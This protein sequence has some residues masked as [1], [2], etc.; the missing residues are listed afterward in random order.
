VNPKAVP[1]M[2]ILA[3]V[4]GARPGGAPRALEYAKNARA[5]APNDPEVAHAAGRAAFQVG[6]HEWAY[7]ILQD[8][9]RKQPGN[10]E[11]GYDF[12]W[13]A[14]SVGRVA[15]AETA[16][17]NVVRQG[18]NSARV[19]AAKLFVEMTALARNPAG[20]AQASPRIQTVLKADPAYVPALT[21]AA[22][23]WE[24]QKGYAEA[25]KLYEQVLGRYPEFLPAIRNLA[26]IY[27]NHLGDVQKGYD[28]AVKARQSLP[29][30]MA[31]AR[32]LGKLVSL[33][34]DHQYAVRLLNEVQQKKA[35]DAETYYYLGVSQAQLKLKS[36]STASL[37]QALT[38]NLDAKLAAEALNR[39]LAEDK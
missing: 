29:D 30:D 17:Q 23:A 37:R 7:S 24:Q 13:S 15:D 26:I 10:V 19:D 18:T 31:L 21:A 25:G 6:Q 20:L 28:L 39:L 2:L 5:A 32:A 12:A 35:A 34:G 3:R 38:M 14:Y 4:H 36:E 27:A 22:L 1:A 16:M 33:R 8:G 11:V 9:I